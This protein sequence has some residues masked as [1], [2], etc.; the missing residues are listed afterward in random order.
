MVLS[1]IPSKIRSIDKK[2]ARP[3]NFNGVKFPVNNKIDKHVKKNMLIYYYYQIPKNSHYV[4]IKDFNRF[5]TNKTKQNGKNN[6][7]CYCYN[8]F[9]AQEY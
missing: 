9:L 8:D 1:Q 5:M 2:F 7:C 4:L 3:V 6:F